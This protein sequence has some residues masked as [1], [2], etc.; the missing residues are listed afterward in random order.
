MMAR[1][2]PPTAARCRAAI[3]ARRGAILRGVTQPVAAACGAFVETAVLHEACLDTG[4]RALV[5]RRERLDCEARIE[6][7]EQL[8]VLSGGPRLAGITR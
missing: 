6:L 4:P 3:L 7:P 8:V 5:H 2:D 1:L